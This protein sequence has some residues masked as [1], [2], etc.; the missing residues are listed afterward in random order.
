MTARNETST[1]ARF[2]EASVS[3]AGGYVVKYHGSQFTGAGVPDILACIDSAF[4]GIE[5]KL[6]GNQVTVAQVRHGIGIVRAGGVFVVAFEDF[7]LDSI[8]GSVPVVTV[9]DDEDEY[10]VIERV[11]DSGVSYRVERA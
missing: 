11:P 1:V 9:A 8:G 6:T 3:A 2:V 10:D 5:A 4:V 7:S